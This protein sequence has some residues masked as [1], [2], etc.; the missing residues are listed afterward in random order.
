MSEHSK[1][2]YVVH[3][4]GITVPLV[5]AVAIAAPSVVHVAKAETEP[6]YAMAQHVYYDPSISQD[7]YAKTSAVFDAYNAYRVAQGLPEVRFDQRCKSVAG[8]FAAESAEYGAR[9]YHLGFPEEGGLRYSEVVYFAGVDETPE[10]VVAAW[11][12]ASPAHLR[13]DAAAAEVNVAHADDGRLVYV[14]AYQYD[15]SNVG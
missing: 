5:F 8:S 6:V 2:F 11:A 10:A 9:V 3:A 7:D 12:S 15:G 1:A 14:L 4:I 13:C